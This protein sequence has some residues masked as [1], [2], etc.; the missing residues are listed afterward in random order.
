MLA[1]APD[2]VRLGLRPI[3]SSA[4]MPLA[5]VVYE[6]A[7]VRRPGDWELSDGRTDDGNLASAELGLSIFEGLVERIADFLVKFH[8]SCR[9]A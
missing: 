6:G 9:Q 5:D 8:E 4:S 1:L 2:L 3:D 7:K